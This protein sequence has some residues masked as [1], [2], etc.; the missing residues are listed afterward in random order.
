MENLQNFI[1]NTSI[2]LKIMVW[3]VIRDHFSKKSINEKKSLGIAGQIKCAVCGESYNVRFNKECPFCIENIKR[4]QEE[5]EYQKFLKEQQFKERL[6]REL[7][8]KERTSEEENPQYFFTQIID[9]IE[10]QF[11][12]ETITDEDHLQAQIKIFLKAKF[13]LRKTEREQPASHGNLIDILVDEKYA[14]EVKVPN[15]RTELR[16]LKAQLEEYKDEYPL[17]CAIILDNQDLNLSEQI[18][19]YANEYRK[20]LGIR[21]VILRGKKREPRFLS[22]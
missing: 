15:N 10:T 4:E 22:Y 2:R 21:T 6:E 16:N 5:K 12:P 1:H 11:N 7:G 20:K 9:S 17:I 8:E 3:D 14:F 13:P 19:A 18:E